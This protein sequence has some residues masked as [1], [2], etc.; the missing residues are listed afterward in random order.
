MHTSPFSSPGGSLR[1]WEG[2]VMASSLGRPTQMAS[3]VQAGGA[4][5]PHFHCCQ[6]LGTNR[7]TQHRVWRGGGMVAGEIEKQAQG[8]NKAPSSPRTVCGDQPGPGPDPTCRTSLGRRCSRPNGCGLCKERNRGS[9]WPPGSGTRIAGL[10]DGIALICPRAPAPRELGWLGSVSAALLYQLHQPVAAARAEPWG[11]SQ[12]L[13][14]ADKGIR[15]IDW[16]PPQLSFLGQ[17]TQKSGHTGLWVRAAAS[18]AHQPPTEPN[19]VCL[20]QLHQAGPVREQGPGLLP[21]AVVQGPSQWAWLPGSQ[22]L[23]VGLLPH[24]VGRRVAGPRGPVRTQLCPG[25]VPSLTALFP[26]RPSG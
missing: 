4:Q 13:V 10:V 24:T 21:A 18:P 25:P 7:Q 3:P 14:S 11:R 17:R 1:G 20:E 16:R 2:E 5:N 22:L 6:G 26:E 15:R 9:D 12:H 8:N 23:P 19:S